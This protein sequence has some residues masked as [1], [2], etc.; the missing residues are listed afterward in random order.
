[1]FDFTQSTGQAAHRARREFPEFQIVLQPI[2]D[3]ETETVYAYEALSRGMQGEN[4]AI[5]IA[6]LDPMQVSA[7]DKLAMAKSLRVAAKLRLQEKGAKIAINLG[8]RLDLSGRDV[9]YVLR[10]AKHYRLKTSS[11]VLELSEGVRMSGGKLARI[12]GIHRAAGVVIAID[13]FGAGYAGLN[14]LATCR[15]DVVKIDRELIQGIEGNK[16]KK[17]IVEAF[18]KVC[19]KLGVDLIAEGVETYAEFRTLRGFGITL[20][21]GYLFAH[22]VG[23]EIPQVRIPPREQRRFPRVTR[24][25]REWLRNALRQ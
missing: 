12:V 20:M 18:A 17:T 19:R 15:P 1:M 2:V 6:D 24:D 16:A 23:C 22:P 4:Y 25:E 8:P 13:D 5:L 10:L 14:I 9:S 3:L 11:V 7:F 21:Q